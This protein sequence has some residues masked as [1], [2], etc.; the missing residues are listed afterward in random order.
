M[1]KLAH[2]VLQDQLEQEDQRVLQV[3]LVRG[4]ALDHQVP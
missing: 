1:D 3:L 2:L 4:V